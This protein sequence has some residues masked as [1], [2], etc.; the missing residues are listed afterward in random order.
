MTNRR[1]RPPTST[2]PS[3]AC[4]FI[5]AVSG[6]SHASHIKCGRFGLDS[7]RRPGTGVGLMLTSACSARTLNVPG[8]QS[9]TLNTPLVFTGAA[10]SNAITVGDSGPADTVLTI[11]LS[12]TNGALALANHRQPDHDQRRSSTPAHD[13]HRHRHRHRHRGCAA[14]LLLNVTG[15]DSHCKSRGRGS[16]RLP[17][18]SHEDQGPSNSVPICTFRT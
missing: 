16:P 2:R 5:T 14:R 7:G 1:Q 6:G 4:E 11:A 15:N 13:L 12:V 9:T 8:A 10:N 3:T 17:F 18:S